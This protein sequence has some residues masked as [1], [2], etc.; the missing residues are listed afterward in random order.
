MLTIAN[1]VLLMVCLPV[2]II[3]SVN[4]KVYA[5]LRYLYT[6]EQKA[7]GRPK[8]YDG[9]MVVGDISRL[10]FIGEHDD[11]KLYS[12]VVN[13]VIL[14]RDSRIVYLCK[15]NQNR[16]SIRPVI[17]NRYRHQCTDSVSVLQG[18][19]SNRIFVSGY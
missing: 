10:V 6:G 2:A 17:F 19:L 1:K 12:A 18:S 16:H 5:N 14:K 3:K 15:K 8:R 11:V 9:K 4:C 7:K 13:G